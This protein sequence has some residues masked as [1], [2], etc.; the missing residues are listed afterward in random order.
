MHI[1]QHLNIQMIM[2]ITPTSLFV[3]VIGNCSLW[4]RRKWRRDWVGKC[5]STRKKHAKLPKKAMSLKQVKGGFTDVWNSCNCVIAEIFPFENFHIA[6][7]RSHD[8]ILVNVGRFNT[9][10]PGCPLRNQEY[11]DPY[12]H[13]PVFET[14][15]LVGTPLLCRGWFLQK[16][17]GTNVFLM[18]LSAC[19]KFQFF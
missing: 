12:F 8:K 15:E 5:K 17:E 19:S 9:L 2:K 10:D 6:P 13:L 7:T 14:P 1:P 16:V 11:E 3:Q 4:F 18:W